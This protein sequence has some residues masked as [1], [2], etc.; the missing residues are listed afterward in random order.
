MLFLRYFYYINKITTQT[1]V[2]YRI[3]SNSNITYTLLAHKQPEDI[4]SLKL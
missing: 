3:Y 1:D 2:D 4:L